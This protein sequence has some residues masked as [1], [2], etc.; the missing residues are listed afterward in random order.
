ME[1]N[2][3]MALLDPDNPLILLQHLQCAAF[4]L[5]FRVGDSFG[6]LDA[7]TLE[8]FLQVLKDQNVLVQKGDRILWTSQEYPSSA[9]SLRSTATR[10]IALQVESEDDKQIIGELDY[11]SSL[12]MTHP[13]AIYLHEGDPYLVKSL[14]LEENVATLEAV[15]LP[16]YTEPVKSQTVNIIEDLNHETLPGYD[17]HFSEVEVTTQVT[18]F[19]KIDWSSREILSIESLEMPSTVLRTYGFWI[20][21]KP[22]IIEKMRMIKMWTSDPNDYGPTWEKQRN[23]ARQRDQYRCYLCGISEGIKPHHVHHK[24]PFRLFSDARIANE[25]TNLV[26]LCQNCHH[27]VELNVKIRSAISGLNYA[28]FHLAP[29]QVMCDEN[30]LGSYADPMADFADKQPIILLYDAIPAGMGLT[31]TLYQQY[32]ALLNNACDLIAHCECEDGCP[33]CVGPISEN[34]IGGKKET[35][36]LLSL[37]LNG[38]VL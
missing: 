8:T 22:E 34:G 16:Y 31:Q 10:S 1:R 18:A 13:G 24:I 2:P 26:T 33:S 28:L 9:I 14:N 3:E 29:L 11:A 19:K 4:E 30:D 15:H 32:L 27:L 6:A 38:E 35:K 21:I 36:A 20:A 5:P 23:L 12:W 17:I 7:A 37:L 25:L